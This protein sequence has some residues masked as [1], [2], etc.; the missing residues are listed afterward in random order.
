MVVEYDDEERD[1]Y[2][3]LGLSHQDVFDEGKHSAFPAPLFMKLDTP[4]N[5]TLDSFAKIAPPSP[6]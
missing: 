6:A 5:E 3:E 2:E 4:L 1:V